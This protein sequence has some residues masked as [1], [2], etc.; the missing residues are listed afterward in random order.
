MCP[1]VTTAEAMLGEV[2]A[3]TLQQLLVTVQTET[4]SP[5]KTQLTGLDAVLTSQGANMKP[6]E[7]PVRRGDV[8]EIQGSTATG[9]TS[10]LYHL[11]ITCILPSEYQSANIGGWNKAA[12]C[13]D[14][15][16][17]FDIERFHRLLMLRLSRL[18]KNGG[19][20]PETTLEALFPAIDELASLCLERLHVFRPASSFQM[21]ATLLDLPR[22]HCARPSLQALEIGLVT[23][24]S[25]SAFYWADRFTVEHSC[26][27]GERSGGTGRVNPLRHVLSALQELRASRGPVIV[28]TNWGLNPL[29]KSVV[30]GEEEETS[31][32]FKQHLQSFPSPFHNSS[33]DPA[34][35]P[36]RGASN[37]SPHSV[38]RASSPL[39]GHPD[40]L[41]RDLVDVTSGSLPL[42]HHITLRM[43]PMDPLPSSATGKVNAGDASRSSP[44]QKCQYEGIVRTPV[45]ASVGRFNFVITEQDVRD[46]L[47]L[48]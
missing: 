46:D 48:V 27:A 41:M 13:F 8:L 2:Q 9:K 16:G 7:V 6:Q 25:L 38:H 15:D 3:E 14:T 23:V 18:I 11:L 4:C 31:P 24:D 22:Y 1:I 19:E 28:L 47:M 10:L 5:C 45:N 35:T 21:A 42:T 30:S 29:K 39:P 34:D 20:P 26:S 43:A 17:T 12:I 32:F 37:A 40:T 36:L 33:S 44:V